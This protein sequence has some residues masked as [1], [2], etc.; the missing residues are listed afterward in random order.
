MKSNPYRSLVQ[1]LQQ[2]VL[3]SP[4]F[5]T[6]DSRPCIHRVAVIQRVRVIVFAGDLYFVWHVKP[7]YVS[8]IL[9]RALHIAHNDTHLNQHLLAKTCNCHV[10]MLLFGIDSSSAP[11]SVGLIGDDAQTDFPHQEHLS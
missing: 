3:D 7:Q 4:D 8:V 11:R 2:L 10:N 6:D 5:E 9:S 1:G